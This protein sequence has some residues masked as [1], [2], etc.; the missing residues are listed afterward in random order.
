MK[1][2]II[3]SITTLYLFIGKE[4]EALTAGLLHRISS[5]QNAAFGCEI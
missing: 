2:I 4:A 1:I 3:T 5:R